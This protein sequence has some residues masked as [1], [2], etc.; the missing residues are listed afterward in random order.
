MSLVAETETIGGFH[1]KKTAVPIRTTLNELGHL[2]PPT[3]IRTDNSTSHGIL[4]S[5]IRQ[6]ISKAFDMN[7][8]WIK[9]RIKRKQVYFF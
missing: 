6:K 4:T 5:T 2:Q 9:D 7:I 1:N 3:T 8:Y